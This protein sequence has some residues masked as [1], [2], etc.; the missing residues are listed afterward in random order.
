MR[1]S[2]VIIPVFTALLPV[3][4]PSDN[5]WALT[6]DSQSGIRVP[7]I[8]RDGTSGERGWCLVAGARAST[9]ETASNIQHPISNIQHPRSK[10]QDPGSAY[11]VPMSWI[12][13]EIVA[14]GGAVPF[15]AFMDL[16]LYHPDH[17]YYSSVSPRYGRA[18]DYLTAPTASRWY[19]RVVGR[20]LRGVAGANGPSR[21]IDLAAGDGS[22]LAGLISSLGTTTAGVI[23]G[24]V[25]V[26]RSDAMR[27]KILDRVGGATVCVSDLAEIGPV[28]ATTIVH[29]SELY[30]A[31]PVARAVGRDGGLREMWV[32][33]DDA[34][35]GWSERPPRE[36]I[37]AYFDDRGVVLEE[38][39]IAE[40]NL[41]A[42]ASHREALQ[43][44][45]ADGLMLVLDYGYETV[46]LYNPR[47]RRGGSLATFRRHRVGRDPLEAPGESDITAHVNWD[48][49]RAAS[50]EEGWME[51]GLWPLAEF[52]VRAGLAAELEERGLGMEAE[53]DAATFSARQEVKRLL[54]PDGMGSDLKV[55]VQAHGAMVEIASNL[56]AMSTEF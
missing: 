26:E 48:D 3:S 23:D 14:R 28:Q 27:Q 22:F 56:L 36:E 2:T 33:V 10:I 37:T 20:L 44:A 34:N 18:A 13:D 16:A 50:R 49:L 6:A 40:A 30:D 45:G 25:A 12:V 17:G 42:V 5:D 38:G 15:D 24:A 35:L 46:R 51:I 8:V 9:D 11:N 54:D 53:I 43:V 1:R 32:T 41:G 29:A 47:G 7:N 4:A 52:L 19:A 39:Q 21:I 55:L 31:H